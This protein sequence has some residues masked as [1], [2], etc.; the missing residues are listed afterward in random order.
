MF[1]IDG[2]VQVSRVQGR[3]VDP[4]PVVGVHV[5]H[6]A[7]GGG[8]VAL[9]VV[10]PVKLH[11]EHVDL[12]ERES[13]GRILVLINCCLSLRQLQECRQYEER[14]PAPRNNCLRVRTQPRRSRRWQ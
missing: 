13:V 14:S 8:L 5:G 10:R 6:L 9:A 2:V 4:V 11:E 7:V 12:R 1:H 3:R